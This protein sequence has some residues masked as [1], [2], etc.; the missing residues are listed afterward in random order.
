MK[1]ILLATSALVLSA[2]M[3]S[4]QALNIGGDARMGVQYRSGGWGGGLGDWRMERRVNLN[5]AATVQGDHGLSFGMFTRVRWDDGMVGDFNG[6]NVWVEASGLRLTFGNQAGPI[7]AFGITGAVPM[8]YTGGT[9]QQFGGHYT[10]GAGSYNIDS[11]GAGMSQLAGV[12]YSMGDYR[13]GIA[14]ARGGHTEVAG[15]ASFDAFTVAA[16]WANNAARYRTISASYNAGD[17]GAS[18]IYSR[19]FGNDFFTLGGRV[20]VGGGTAS[21]YVGQHNS[22]NVGGISYRYGLGGGATIGA[23]LERVAG[24]ENRAELGVIFSF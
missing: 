7:E 17:W 10:G 1:K 18:A 21:A 3:A 6:N 8:G 11:F 12:T 15:Q 16:G 14:R 5:F 20:D 19:I 4:S 22:M 2:G 13:V 23:N 9:F 24:G